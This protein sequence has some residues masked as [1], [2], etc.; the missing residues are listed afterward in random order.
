MLP[1]LIG[2][3][4]GVGGFEPSKA[5][6]KLQHDQSAIDLKALPRNIPGH[7]GG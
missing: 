7:L 6:W 2:L 1:F 4:V 5:A 3:L